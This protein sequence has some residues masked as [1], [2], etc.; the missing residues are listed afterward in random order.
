MG[1]ASVSERGAR[2]SGGGVEEE[3]RQRGRG[4]IAD[5]ED[6]LRV[7]DGPPDD[8]RDAWLEAMPGVEL[9]PPADEGSRLPPY[10]TTTCSGCRLLTRKSR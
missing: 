8:Q 6:A 2:G 9:V 7:F 3:R 1:R 5:A 4:R 10:T